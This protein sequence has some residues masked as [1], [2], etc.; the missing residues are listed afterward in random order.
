[1]TLGLPLFNLIQSLHSQFRFKRGNLKV[2]L[3][4]VSQ[5]GKLS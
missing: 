3:S 5:V 4:E 2:I 1:M